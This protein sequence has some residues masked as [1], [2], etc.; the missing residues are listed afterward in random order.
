VP[1]EMPRLIDDPQP[2]VTSDKLVI[3][4]SGQCVWVLDKGKLLAGDAPTVDASSCSIAQDNQVA[5]VKYGPSPPSTAYSV[6]MSDDTHINWVSVDGTQAGNDIVVTEHKVKV[7]RVDEVPTFGGVTQYNTGIESGQVKAMWHQNHIAW[8]KTVTCA[9]GTCVRLFD[10]DT[11]LNMV[12]SHDFS[13]AGTQLFYGGAGLDK[14]GNEWVLMAAAKPAKG[15]GLALAGVRASGTIEE[16]MIV[17][18]DLSKISGERFGDYFSA[19]QDPDG[20]VWLIGQFGGTPNSP[21]NHE[22]S[23]GCKL[24]HVTVH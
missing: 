18:A 8:S 15:I 24:V 7:P 6:T 19:A 10:I 13:M 23:A 11:S 14:F 9:T 17:Q 12:T 1:I 16:P 4:E 21:L 3:T 20:S 2:T 22:N 5:A